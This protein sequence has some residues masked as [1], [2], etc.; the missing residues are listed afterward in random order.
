MYHDRYYF[1]QIWKSEN[2]YMYN[3]KSVHKNEIFL[4]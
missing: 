2:L 3:K 4:I 1:E